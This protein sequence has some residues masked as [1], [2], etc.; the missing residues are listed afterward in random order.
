[1]IAMANYEESAS[2]AVERAGTPVVLPP[3]NIFAYSGAPV[4]MFA[5][6]AGTLP[7]KYQW[8]HDGT[9]LAGATG[10]WLSLANV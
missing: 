5:R 8:Q 7:L 3:M 10:P 4:V 2:F 9:N 1:V 6:V